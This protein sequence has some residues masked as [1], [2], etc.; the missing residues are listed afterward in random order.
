MTVTT[1][2]TYSAIVADQLYIGGWREG[3]SERIATTT[4]P[5]NDESIA[6]IRQAS[7]DDV[8][9][10]YEIA[11]ESQAVWAALAPKERVHILTKAAD[12]IEEN[13]EAVIELIRVESGSTAIKA[14]IETS[15][16]VGSLREAA[17]FPTRI[18][19]QIL[20]S[21]T[22]GKANYVFREAL[23]VVGVISPWNF[24]FALSMR[25]VAP[26]LAC[27]NAVVVK[28]ASDTPLTGGLLL[29][30]IFE[31]AGL[32]EGVLNIV[33]GSGSEIGDHFVEHPI[34][35]LISFTGS[36]PVGKQV[37]ATATGGKHIKKVAL[38]LGGNAPLVVL[39]DADLDQAVGAAAM[40]KF[41]HQGQICMA[42]N[43]IIV[44]AP[45]YDEFVEAFAKRVQTLAYGDQCDDATVVGPVINDSQLHSVTKKIE[46][47]RIEGAREVVS[48]PIEGR[49]IAPHVF[50]DVTP[51]MELFREEIFGPVVG[52]IKAKDEA[53][54]LELA[55]DTEFGLSSAVYTRD[56][57]RGLNFARQVEAGMTHVNDI[58]V[59][60]EAHVMFGGEKNSGLGRFNG[61]W[62]IEEFTTT[63]WVGVAPGQAQFPF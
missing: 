48:G 8:D 13:Q 25:S 10:A 12:W 61:E 20:P 38:E 57:A 59:N 54:A 32:P 42:V 52:I 49:V 23:G 34:P 5:F 11:K 36:T 4:N 21:N 27:G 47:A 14:T 30:K 31:A 7:P 17:T 50:A 63:H 22:P 2:T 24:P 9:A 33:V 35:R 3:T 43:R 29:G 19:G 60:D 28:P 39:E 55:N 53:H 44:Q 26:A 56:L 15:L 16:A 6:T 58:T 41:L 45:L 1:P 18:T 51:A 40:G 37:G 62:A 46:R